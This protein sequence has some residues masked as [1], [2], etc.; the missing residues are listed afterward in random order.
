[1]CIAILN[2]Y[3]KLSKETIKNAWNNNDQGGG[4]LYNHCGKLQTYKT[5]KFKDLWKK[6]S[7]LRNN[8]ET[9][10]IVLHFRIATSGY[11]KYTNLHPFLVSDNLGFVHN[12]IISNLGDNQFSDTYYFNELLRK[13]PNDF[14]YNPSIVKLIE[15]TIGSSKLIFLDSND[16]HTIVNEKFGKWDNE[17]N[18]FSNNSHECS[19]EYYYY[20]NEV[21]YKEDTKRTTLTVGEIDTAEENTEYLKRYFKNATPETLDELLYYIGKS[22]YT[23]DV[24]DTIEDISAYYKTDDLKE[25]TYCLIYDQHLNTI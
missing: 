19:L 21:I 8:T 11:E 20:G 9:G 5:Y 16:T 15:N 22:L 6:Y 7:D 17:E 2:T 3:N 13:L 18:W 25:L 14:L 12:G 23:Y 10:K 4:L 24:I 1:M